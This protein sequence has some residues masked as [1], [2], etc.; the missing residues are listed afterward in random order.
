MYAVSP[1][2]AR[3]IP[4]LFGTCAQR[5]TDL[6]HPFEQQRSRVPELEG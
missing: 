5:V 4:E 2:Y 6:I 1:T 3:H